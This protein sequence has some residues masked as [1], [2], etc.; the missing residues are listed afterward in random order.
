MVGSATFTMLKSNCSTN[1][2]AQIKIIASAGA[3]AGPSV[4]PR[5]RALIMPMPSAS[6]AF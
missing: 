5:P 2:A 6:T 1:C 3:R 4:A